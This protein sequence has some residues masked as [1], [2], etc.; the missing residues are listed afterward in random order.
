MNVVG[1]LITMLVAQRK[2]TPLKISL[3]LCSFMQ[4]YLPPLTYC[5]GCIIN[6]PF[7]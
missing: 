6:V 7:G 4:C 2:K 3:K 5:L 1:Q